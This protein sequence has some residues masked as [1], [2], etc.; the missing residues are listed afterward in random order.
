MFSNEEIKDRFND[1]LFEDEMI[2]KLN[3]EY[4]LSLN[5]DDESKDFLCEVRFPL[6][7]CIK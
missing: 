6:A 1:L 2:L 4:A 3:R 7:I 5:I